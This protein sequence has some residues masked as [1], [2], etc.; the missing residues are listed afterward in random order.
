V[1][2]DLR[3][4]HTMS[5]GHGGMID[6]E[7]LPSRIRRGLI[8]K[9]RDINDPSIFHKI[10]LIPLLAWIGL[11]ADGLS[12]SA[13]GPEEAFKA[14]G[15]HK[16]LAVILALMTVLTVSIISF[17]YAKIIEHF[18]HG[19]GGYIVSTHMLGKRAGVVSGSALLVDY[20]LTISI[21]IAACSD[22][23]FS[24][25]PVGF[26]QLKL[27]FSILLIIILIVLNIRG[28][29]E[30]VTILAPIFMIF[31]ITH[32]VLLGY[33]ILSHT[34][35]VGPVMDEIG[36][37]LNYDLSTIGLAGVLLILLHAYSLGG[38][39]YTGIEAVSNGLQIMREPKVQTG[40]RTMLYMAV[41][42][43]LTAGGI[44][45]CYLLWN[46]SPVE[47]KTLNAVLANSVFGHWNFG[48]T[49]A[50]ITIFSEGAI[51]VV[52]A[53]TGFIDGPR[54][55]SNM[56]VDSWLPRRFATL[57]DRL[58]MQNGVLLMGISAL[59]LVLFTRGSVAAL[60]VMYAINVFLTFS[61]SQ[62]AMARFYFLNRAKD[63]KWARHASIFTIGFLLC[64]TILIMTL[65]LKFAEGGW[66]TIAI[67]SVVIA[68]CLIIRTHYDK[69][70]AEFKKLDLMLS[71][72]PSTEKR[73][74]KPVDPSEMT[75]IQLVTGYN[76][77]GIH[78]FL[79]IARNFPNLYKNFIFVSI[80]V[81]D[82]G[83]F[84][85][86]AEIEN[87]KES[88]LKE[89]EKYV[90]L[91]RR[92]GFSAEYRFE[93][94]IDV[95]ESATEICRVTSA[96]FPHSTVFAGQLTFDMEK[97][98]HRLLHNE[99]AF[100]IQRRLHW[101]GITAVILPIRM[102]IGKAKKKRLEKSRRLS[103]DK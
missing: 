48:Q 27:I 46:I 60:V 33:G 11:G 86:K 80:A 38:G 64:A 76:G 71:E 47:G 22:A 85:G 65:I 55:M 1:V 69:V 88:V 5:E 8:G 95:V 29:K 44:S 49:L 90:D 98:Y 103:L 25:L 3:P 61:L 51:L 82:T 37:S 99:T 83:S 75:A 12:S 92:F 23:V 34:D 100:A 50:F 53:Q 20:M 16:Y 41:S 7:S 54:V 87:L 6:K 14:L 89:L 56:A 17:A 2:I 73:N 102:T 43:A 63:K 68:L 78:T 13:Y 26:Q 93:T 15:E 57:S 18:P 84:K 96:K 36:R 42:L 4:V 28:V 19:G 94:G 97:F 21:S 30:S 66:L 101:E 79:S 32:G 58:T 40:K 9:P 70:K 67:T 59:A 62:F 45:V 91:A 31:I 77:F 39:T 10:A 81:I 35:R 24:F 74:T 72:L 52:A